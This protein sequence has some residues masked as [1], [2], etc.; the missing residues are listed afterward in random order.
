[1]IGKIQY[2]IENFNS[3]IFFTENKNIF[4][5]TKRALE[6]LNVNYPSS[7]KTRFVGRYP[8]SALEFEIF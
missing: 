4:K 1:M 2:F 5:V 3:D 6:F 7:L 8:E